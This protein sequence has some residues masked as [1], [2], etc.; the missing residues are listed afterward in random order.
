MKIIAEAV[1]L[2]VLALSGTL[3][4]TFGYSLGAGDL[5][6]QTIAAFS[7][8]LEV[9]KVMLPFVIAS[10]WRQ[11]RIVLLL[12]AVPALPLLIGYSFA[13]S[14]GFAEMNRGSLTGVRDAAAERTTTL[15]GDIQKLRIQRHTIDQARSL[16][17]IDTD[18]EATE[19]QVFRIA[20]EIKTLTE[21]TSG[22]SRIIG[23]KTEDECGRLTTFKR[24]R[25]RAQEHLRLATEL[26]AKETTLANAGGLALAGLGD[27]QIAALTHL[28][29]FDPKSVRQALGLVFA[30]LIELIGGF[31]L[32][33]ASAMAKPKATPANPTPSL[34]PPEPPAITEDS[35][36]LA[37]RYLTEQVQTCKGT[38]VVASAMHRDYSAWIASLGGYPMTLTSF[39][40]LVARHGI[41]KE[42]SEG[43]IYYQDVTL[44]SSGTTA[45]ETR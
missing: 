10:A 42:R 30:A 24:E 17:E 1:S 18:I 11:G 5:E 32:F 7:V 13:A 22:C 29:G 12:I 19:R 16:P 25:A 33:F 28:S 3:A 37:L 14:L 4:W 8:A 45:G 41:A 20:G 34:A 35:E 43:R 9:W 23:K 39:G 26:T 40:N 15:R 44:V 31:G 27:P 38:S 21:L 36:T 2:V 6:R